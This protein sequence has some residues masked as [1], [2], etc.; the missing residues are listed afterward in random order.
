ML[1]S[2]DPKDD[3]GRRLHPYVPELCEQ[4]R[5]GVLERRE[6]LRTATLLG[7]AAGTAY[8]MAGRI[9]G[10]PW[11]PPA[12]QAAT[13]KK[14]GTLKWGMEVQEMEDPATF[15][16]TQASN[17]SR[18]IVEYLTFT[19]NDNITRP[20][21][22]EGWEASRDLKTWTFRLRRG[23]TWSNGDDFGADDV[24]TNFTRWLDPATGSSNIGLFAAMVDELDEGKTDD[25]GHPL[26]T[27]RMTKG[28]VE[29]VDD[30]TVRLHLNSPVLSIPESLYNYPTAILHRRFAEEGGSLARNPVGTGPYALAEFSVGERAVLTRR[31]GYWG[32]APYLDE[33]QYLDM[34]A[35]RSAWLEAIAAKRIDGIYEFDVDQLDAAE[36]LPGVRVSTATTAQTAV[37]R[38]RVDQAPFDNK[39]LRRAIQACADRRALLDIAYRGKGAPGEDHHVSPIHPEY[40]EL[41]PLRQDYEKAKALL[42]AAGHGGGLSLKIDVGNTS[43]SWEG[44]AMEALKAQLAPAGIA[45]EVNVVPPAR[46]REIWNRTP[47]GFTSWTH[48]PLGVMVL[49]LGYRSGV[50]W[51]ESRYNNS[52]FDKALDVASAILDIDARRRAMAKVQSILQDDAVIVQPL[53]SILQDDAVIVQPLWRA[54]FSARRKQVKGYRTHPTLYHQFQKVWLA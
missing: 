26:K 19:G 54:V 10:G 7:V 5:K 47:F 4:L 18:H 12:A 36:A 46:Y 24:V 31:A 50:P 32:R 29:K 49:D 44:D 45:L 35:D 53:W 6:F 17:L 23:I 43:G 20:Y 22:A 51:N 38:M 13:P 40:A 41:P 8:A 21:L 42:A 27:R 14:G 2:K 52:E 33:I 9:T 1:M 37:A 25:K 16:W 30:H 11:A 34:G 15:A 39:E 48:R 3:C 28:A